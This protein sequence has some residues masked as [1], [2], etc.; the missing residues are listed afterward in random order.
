MI[1]VV[2]HMVTDILDQIKHLQFVLYILIIPLKSFTE[3]KFIGIM[4]VRQ[5]LEFYRYFVDLRGE[6]DMTFVYPAIFTP[7]ENDS[8]YHVTFP[9]L[10]GCW[11][12]GADLEDAIDDA[13]DAE[14]NW[15]ELQMDEEWGGD[16]PKASLAEE[17]EVPEGCLVKNLMVRVKLLPDS[18]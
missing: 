13:K 16:I 3:K 18:D 7:H 12:D 4:P 17:I 8:G 5:N 15:L 14:Y 10:E 11:G 6:S 9:D 1:G 2:I